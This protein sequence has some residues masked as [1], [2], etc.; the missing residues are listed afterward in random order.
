MNLAQATRGEFEQSRRYREILAPLAL[1][2]EL[3]AV[4]ITGDSCWGFM[5]MSRDQS[6]PHFTL[7]EAAY[8][9]R[10]TPHFAEGL[11]KALLLGSTTGPTVREEPGL[12]LLADDLTVVATTPAAERWLAEVGE[13]DWP[14]KQALPS[15]VSAVVARL[16]ALERN[17]Y[18]S[19]RFDAEGS[20]G[21][22]YRS[23]AGAARLATCLVRVIQGAN[24]RDLRG[25]P[26][27]G[28]GPTSI[29]QAYRISPDED[30]R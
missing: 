16:Q 25:G 30:E 13:A 18:R 20:P 29:L 24:R 23:L 26:A 6:S 1:G 8:L 11:R 10:L 15:A 5:C 14:R 19:A 3:R 21:D 17:V 4:L 9:A 7:T 27:N 2:D 28:G 22:G 12:L